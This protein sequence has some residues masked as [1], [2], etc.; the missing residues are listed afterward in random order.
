MRGPI[1]LASPQALFSQSDGIA[2]LDAANDTGR[3]P[4]ERPAAPALTLH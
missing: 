2:A 3:N 1:F 4:H